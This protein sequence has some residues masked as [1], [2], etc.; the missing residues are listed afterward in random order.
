MCEKMQHF[1]KYIEETNN[2]RMEISNEKEIEVVEEEYKEKEKEQL[3]E[4]LT[5]GTLIM[6]ADKIVLQKNLIFKATSDNFLLKPLKEITDESTIVDIEYSIEG[7]N[8]KLPYKNFIEMTDSYKTFFVE[9]PS[10]KYLDKIKK[11]SQEFLDYYKV[12]YDQNN[13][14]NRKINRKKVIELINTMNTIPIYFENQQA[15]LVETFKNITEYSSK[16]TDCVKLFKQK[17]IESFLTSFPQ[18][19]ALISSNLRYDVLKNDISN[20]YTGKL[21]TI[22][23]TTHTILSQL[24][25]NSKV[26]KELINSNVFQ[27]RI[28]CLGLICLMTIRNTKSFIITLTNAWILF[29]QRRLTRN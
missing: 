16:L 21:S 3:I 9:L 10:G 19:S 29:I 14:L 24:I 13:K 15:I 6:L 4:N 17:F 28:R 1:F 11:V 22:L 8:E 5:E 20:L 7:N 25:I 12:N 27:M 2:K 18:F 26:K 23:E